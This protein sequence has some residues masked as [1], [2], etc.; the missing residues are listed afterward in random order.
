[1]LFVTA[2]GAPASY[3]QGREAGGDSYM[4]KPLAASGLL[5]A[6]HMLLSVK[7]RASRRRR[8]RRLSG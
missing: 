1:V 5:A 7:R 2:E 6:V 8:A 4:V 3:A